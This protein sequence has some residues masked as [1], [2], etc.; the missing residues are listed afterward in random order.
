MELEKTISKMLEINV[1]SRVWHWMTDSVQQHTTFENFLTQNETLTDSLVESALGNDIHLNFKQ[2]T[3][4]HPGQDKFDIKIARDEITNY[5]K[6]IHSYKNELSK[7]DLTGADELVTILDD[8]TELSSKTLYL[9][10]LK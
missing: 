7:S 6:L 4:M 3:V 10:K 2:V 9:L 1:K 8:V 5:R